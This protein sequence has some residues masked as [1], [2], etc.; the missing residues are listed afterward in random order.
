MSGL[1][2]ATN[3]MFP[4]LVT[5]LRDD[6]TID[7]ASAERLV[8]HLYDCGVGGLYVGGNTGEGSY[9]SFEQRREIAQL[10]TRFSKGRGRVVVHVG[11]VQA[12]QARELAMHA[13]D[14][15]ADAVSSMPPFVG[16]YSW[17]E[18]RQ[19][20]EWISAASPLP[21]IAYYIPG[22]TRQSFSLQQ[23]VELAELRGIAGYKFTDHNL[24]LMQR[25]IARMRPDQIV[26]HG[27]DELLAFGLAM[28]ARGG[29]GTTYNFMPRQIN[30]IA[31]HCESGNL[32]AA[33][34]TQKEINEVIEVVLSAQGLVVTKLI[35]YWQGLID[36]P[37]CVRPR[38]GL[39][40]TQAG[41]IRQRLAATLLADSLVRE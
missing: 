12:P 24:Y 32:T 16:G 11:A 26:F 35:L 41:T 36:T 1:W 27:A 13:A 9:L 7:A 4:A 8:H 15:G 10:A 34:Q 2:D 40:R 33:V 30:A 17:D 18:V 21:V 23:L 37:V 28:G 38:A 29:I 25:L 5:P 22:V 3:R 6:G 39:N 19:Y 20:Y 14:V 31:A